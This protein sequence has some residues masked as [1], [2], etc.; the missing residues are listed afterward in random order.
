MP[1][2]DFVDLVLR[3]AGRE[4]DIGVLQTLHGWAHSA[5]VHYVAPDWRAE[6][7]RLLAEGALREL[8][9]AEPGSQHQ[10]AWARFFAPCRV[11]RG[12]SAAAAGPAGG[13]REDR[14]AGRRPGAAVGVPGAAGRAR[15]RRRVGDRRR[16][17]PRRHRVRQAPP[18]ALPGRPPLGGGQGA[19]MGGG[20]GVG[21]PVER[22]GRGDHRRFRPAVR[23]GSCS[24]RTPPR[25]SP[26]SSGSGRQRSIQIGMD[27]VQRSVPGA[28]GLPADPGGRGR[29]A[30]GARGRGARRCAGWCWSRGTTWR[31]RCGDR[32]ATPPRRADPDR[33][34][35][36]ARAPARRASGALARSG[37]RSA[38]APSTV[39]RAPCPRA[40]CAVRRGDL[41]GRAHWLRNAGMQS[42]NP[43]EHPPGP[44]PFGTRTPVL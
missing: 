30:R 28:P 20:R 9:R 36:T 26:P 21:R 23:S 6:G 37:R 25:T 31:G 1:A 18:G 15:R 19:G 17:G 16:T 13:H 43:D 5:L 3:F 27:V 10:L 34:T 32:P 7:A 35:S 2:R 22:P 40:P 33:G 24:R 11:G 44:A 39:R 42:R 4:S 8:R 14:R 38:R 29:V 12:R 41:I